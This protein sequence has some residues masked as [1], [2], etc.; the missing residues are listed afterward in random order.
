MRRYSIKINDLIV[1]SAMIILFALALII[2]NEKVVFF[3]LLC[4]FFLAFTNFLFDYNK[5]ISIIAFL[6]SFFTFLIAEELICFLGLRDG[7]YS[8][9]S[10]INLHAYISLLVALVGLCA[11]YIICSGI[12]NTKVNTLKSR[13]INFETPSYKTI[14][15]VSKNAYYVLC[16]F[17]LITTTSA[18]VFALTVGYWNF[19]SEYTF[20]GPAIIVK[21]ANMSTV[22]FFVFLATMPRKKEAQLPI[23]IFAITAAVS[24]IGGQRNGFVVSLLILIIY[25]VYRNDLN[26]ADGEEWVSKKHIILIVI[27]VPVAISLLYIVSRWRADKEVS[28]NLLSDIIDFFDQQGFS[29]NVIKWEKQMDKTIPDKCYSLGQTI[30]FLTS[31]NF[32]SRALFSF[33]TYTGQTIERAVNG[34]RLSYILSY[35]KFPWDYSKGYGVGSSYIAEAYHDFGYIGIAVF[36]II[37]GVFFSK[38]REFQYRSVWLTGISYLC[39]DELLM[40]PRSYADAFIVNIFDFSNI[41]MLLIIFVLASL[42]RTRAKKNAKH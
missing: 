14:R 1:L 23:L 26:N 5:N 34:Y 29:I 35:L 22:A 39:L 10:G 30:E 40:A 27:L 4:V 13:G 6:I 31:G 42:M 17:K 18:A 11:A 41:E 25:F 21:L 3:I 19:Y 7:A 20:S 2:N 33:K 12:D 15:K 24:L 38:L 37:Y 36:S 16:V 9:S 28:F 8:F 32:F